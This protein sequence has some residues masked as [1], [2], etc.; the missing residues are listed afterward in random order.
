MLT[1]YELCDDLHRAIQ[2]D[3]GKVFGENLATYPVEMTRAE[4]QSGRL[5]SL[6]YAMDY[7]DLTRETWR[8][9]RASFDRAYDEFRNT[10]LASWKRQSEQGKD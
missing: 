7:R 8:R 3:F 10:L 5:L 2:E 1:R 4:E 6:I 9:A